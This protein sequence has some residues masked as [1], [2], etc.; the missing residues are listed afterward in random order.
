M[1]NY[2]SSR[3][4]YRYQNQENYASESEEQGTPAEFPV[5]QAPA[6]EGEAVDPVQLTPVE[7][8]PVKESRPNY[9]EEP[10][11]PAKVDVD[12]VP[13]VVR[14]A[15]I[16]PIPAP[17][18]VDVVKGE[19]VKPVVDI[20]HK[21]PTKVSFPHPP[22][23]GASSSHLIYADFTGTPQAGG[24]IHIPA[25][26]S[27]T[28]STNLVFSIPEGFELSFTLLDKYLGAGISIGGS[29]TISAGDAVELKFLAINL[30]KEEQVI[31]DREPVVVGVLRP[32]IAYT[33]REVELPKA[34]V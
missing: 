1:E 12:P 9:T 33:V 18:Q 24:G 16:E 14:Q 11:P 23:D 3:K 7:E 4:N 26:K 22:K 31:V 15:S 27:R 29:T 34:E 19:N 13:Q 8:T 2:M 6:E 21:L 28:I 32:V 25:G 10:V 30:S 5:L 17:K 20:Y